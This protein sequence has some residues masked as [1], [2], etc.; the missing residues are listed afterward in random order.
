MPKE[1]LDFPCLLINA[2]T[3]FEIELGT[4]T[5]SVGKE[6]FGSTPI[7]RMFLLKN[8]ID[9]IMHD[10]SKVEEEARLKKTHHGK[11]LGGKRKKAD[12]KG[13]DTV[14]ISSDSEERTSRK[15]NNKE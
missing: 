14:P 13:E 10:E 1:Q 15:T 6:S 2:F 8:D 5:P 12:N 3:H 9:K 11:I 4:E 7:N